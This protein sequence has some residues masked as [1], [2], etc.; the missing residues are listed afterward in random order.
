M[1]F[2]LQIGD[3]TCSIHALMSCFVLCSHAANVSMN[4]IYE[5]NKNEE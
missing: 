1:S 2:G 4:K 5:P 3:L